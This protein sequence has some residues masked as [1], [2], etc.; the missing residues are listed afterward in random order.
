MHLFPSALSSSRNRICPS[1]GRMLNSPAAITYCSSCHHGSKFSVIFFFLGHVS[2]C[3]LTSYTL[4]CTFSCDVGGLSLSSPFGQLK[5]S[6]PVN[7]IQMLQQRRDTM[8]ALACH[9]P[10][11]VQ[12]FCSSCYYDCVFLSVYSLSYK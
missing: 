3:A 4:T 1:N 2:V 12:L 9:T 11:M 7:R 8:Q 10:Y 5:N 6:P